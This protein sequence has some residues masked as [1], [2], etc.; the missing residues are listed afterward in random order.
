MV[1]GGSKPSLD[2]FF[3]PGL[4][5]LLAYSSLWETAHFCLIASVSC[6]SGTLKFLV[7][8]CWGSARGFSTFTFCIA[9]SETFGV[10]RCGGSAGGCLTLTFCMAGSEVLVSLVL[11]E[12]FR[13]WPFAQ[14]ALKFLVSLAV[15]VLIALAS[16]WSGTLKF[17]VSL[18]VEVLNTLVSC[19]SGTLKFLVSLA[20]EI[21]QE[22]V[23]RWRILWVRN[24]LNSYQITMQWYTFIALC[25]LSYCCFC[26]SCAAL[27]FFFALWWHLSLMFSNLSITVSMSSVSS[28][29]LSPSPA[30][31][32]SSSSA[33]ES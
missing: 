17:L 13:C 32:S 16:C 27:M 26:F 20:V 1:L 21:L 14:Q 33:S 7:S 4:F 22:A 31:S 3:W 19:R 18:A 10:S 30:I 5:E 8:G 15:D 24:T 25:F 2:R 23:W 6:W 9:G 29:S 12:A 11:W 28:S